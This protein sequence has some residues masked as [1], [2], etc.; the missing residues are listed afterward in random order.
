VELDLKAFEGL[1]PFEM[2]GQT[3]F[4]RISDGPYFMT[5]G[6]YASYWFALHEQPHQAAL[7]AA[8]VD[9]AVDFLEALPALLVGA[10]WES[11]L[12]AATR[13]TLERQALIQFLAR[14][15]WLVSKS[16]QIQQA[17]FSEWTHI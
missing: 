17:R 11:V 9:P 16:G 6:P 13:A 2:L 4:P 5:L 14:Q 8:P 7:R 1:I 10:N 3:D 12:D 15:P